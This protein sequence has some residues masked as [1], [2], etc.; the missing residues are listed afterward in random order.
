MNI[1]CRQARDY[2][3]NELNKDVGASNYVAKTKSQ[4]TKEIIFGK[5]DARFR[6]KCGTIAA[7]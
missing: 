7:K 4:N 6:T 5:G 3:R 2:A 1:S